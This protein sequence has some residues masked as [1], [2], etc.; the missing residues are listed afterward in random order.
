MACIT[1]ANMRKGVLLHKLILFEQ[2]LA[3][4]HG[5]FCFMTFKG[6]GWYLSSTAALLYSSY[7]LHNVVAWMKIK[8]F[9]SEPR[10]LFRYRTGK[11]VTRIYLGTLALTVPPLILQI[12][13][14]FRY[15]NNINNLYV[16]VRPY[17]P[18]MRDPWWVFTC[19]TLFHVIRKCYGTGT[20][21][22]MKRSPRFGILLAAIILAMIFTIMDIT[23][24]I[25]K[26][27]GSD[28]INPYWKFSLVFKCLT[29]TIML[30]D[31][32]TELKRL[33]IR[34]LQRDDA[35]RGTIALTLDEDDHDTYENDK[36]QRGEFEFSNNNNRN[37]VP[38]GNQEFGFQDALR[39]GP[40]Q[41]YGQAR[42]PGMK[43][44]MGR[45][46]QKISPLPSLSAFRF[47]AIKAG[48]KAKTDSDEGPRNEHR[49]KDDSSSRDSSLERVRR[50]RRS[51]GALSP[52]PTQ[53]S[54]PDPETGLH[55]H[56]LV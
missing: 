20:L 16:S 6:Y 25:V 48:P 5:T 36:A 14:N 12:F 1:V 24:S 55:T 44:A 45:V 42:K 47:S 41:N 2:L 56:G 52:L 49:E 28:G 15:F 34:R 26:F 22:L 46:G 19:L 29:D 37:F 32:K 35:R 38:N 8:P 4:T 9:F 39:M 11:V 7:F 3:L 33:G 53:I 21:E 40:P 17:E 10:S 51:L 54:Q 50:M 30:D 27:G 13:D 18:L 31:F 23:A 43:E